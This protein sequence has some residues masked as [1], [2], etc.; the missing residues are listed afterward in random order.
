LI[1]VQVFEANVSCGHYVGLKSGAAGRKGVVPTR[2]L[3]NY[4]PRI[5]RG[6]CAAKIHLHVGETIA[7][8]RELVVVG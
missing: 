5:T 4:D 8:D 7:V 3:G 2:K 1:K 6:I